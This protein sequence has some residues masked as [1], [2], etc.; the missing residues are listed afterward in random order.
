MTVS[1][2]RSAPCAALLALSC[3]CAWT[4]AIA[5]P[6]AAP[7]PAPAPTLAE[8]AAIGAAAD[9]LAC[10]DR[11]AGRASAPGPDVAAVD[12]VTGAAPAASA[13]ASTSALAAKNAPV[14]PAR[15]GDGDA[16]L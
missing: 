1:A 8:C 10:Y 11:L 15:D 3:C 9:R 12:A 2:A 14:S 4:P 6:T 16:S 13:P 7:A 5:Q